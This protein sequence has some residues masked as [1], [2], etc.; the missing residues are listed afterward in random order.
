MYLA[1]V[2]L[3]MLVLPVGDVVW[4]HAHGV[5][6]WLALAGKWFVFWGAGIRLA[7]AGVRQWLQPGF[8]A[9]EIFGLKTDEALPLVR[10]L[11]IGNVAIGAVGCASLWVPSL[12]PAVAL[13]AAIA[14][15]GWG[16][17]H[18]RSEA[19]SRN[20]LVAMVSDLWLAGVLVA[21]LVGV[22]G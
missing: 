12:T 19:Q 22:W 9:K 7:A 14:F 3:T 10:E 17:G 15:G 6:G 11:G 20:E 5:A 16:L 13:V 8:T 2:V 21:Y 1:I 18:L 4:E